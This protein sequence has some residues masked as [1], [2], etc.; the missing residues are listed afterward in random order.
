METLYI[1]IVIVFTNEV[2]SINRIFPII[3][4]MRIGLQSGFHLEISVWG[5][6]GKRSKVC[7]L[8]HE[9]M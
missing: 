1:A 5:G 6:G 2:L 4:I 8:V 7:C 3:I 9:I